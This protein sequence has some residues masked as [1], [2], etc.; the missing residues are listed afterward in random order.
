MSDQPLDEQPQ[1]A[2]PQPGPIGSEDG[3]TSSRYGRPAP[4]GEVGPDGAE[5]EAAADDVDLSRPGT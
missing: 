5:H 2:A 1:P 4:P 3:L